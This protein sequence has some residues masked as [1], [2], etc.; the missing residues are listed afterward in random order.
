M[1]NELRELS[2]SLEKAGIKPPIFHYKFPLCPRKPAFMV[3]L[4]N[5]GNVAGVN[6]IPM[7]QV[8]QIRKWDGIG[9]LGTSFPAL[10]IP[11]LLMVKD[12]EHRKKLT[13][14]KKTANILPKEILK[15]AGGA[16]NLW[17]GR[18][19]GK[20]NKFDK[21]DTCLDKPVKDLLSK[22]TDTPSEFSAINELLLRAGKT[23]S[24]KLFSQLQDC[25]IKSIN[26]GDVKPIDALFYYGETKP[27]SQNDFQLIFE[28][29]DWKYFPANHQN[30]QHWMNSKLLSAE[31]G[32]A[33]VK[34]DAFGCNATGKDKKFPKVGF[35]NALGNVILRA[36]S[37]ENPSQFRYGMIN[38][39]SFPAGEEVRKEMTG[40]L[41][42][43]G[44]AENKGKTWCDLSR[45]LDRATLLFA[46]PSVIPPDL[47]DLASMMGD[48]QDA[49]SEIGKERFSTLAEKVTQALQGR[50]NATM[51]VDIRVFVL[52]KR[53][54]DARTKVIA[55][56]RYSDKH[57]IRSAR[58]W[59]EGSENI[60][61]ITIRSFGK[62]KGDKIVI[63]N[64]LIPFPV[65]T[66]WCLNTVWTRQ[67][68]HA[69]GAH[70]F[71]V[72]DSLCLLLGVGHELRHVAT[73]ALNV[74]LHNGLSLYLAL[75]QA[76]AQR[77]V[78][79]T[80]KKY[81]RQTLLLPSIL[82]LLLYKLGCKKGEIMKSP[83]FLVGRFMSIADQLHME[84]WKYFNQERP[85]SKP[86]RQLIGNSHMATALEQPAKAMAMLGQRLLLYQSWAQTVQE[87]ERVGLVKYFLD[88]FGKV[89]EQLNGA[90][91][92]AHCSDIDKAQMLLGYLARPESG[93]D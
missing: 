73:R 85:N 34:L 87:G 93:K 63:S 48:A 12:Q 3:Y 59:Q 54:G 56:S 88:Q 31:I 47:P 80:D 2:I 43:L 16:S 20:S 52:S 91:L 86:P 4:D 66:I 5:K 49:N 18:A 27:T 11:P 10:S 23:D 13:A 44:K 17:S 22:L 92:P 79:K 53:S 60:P 84:H 38:F 65:E 36:M 26:D 15:I 41:E 35:K 70:G 62:N 68:S 57:I 74:I 25:F 90:A 30:V 71:S 29:K 83:T 7:E 58:I 37:Q 33:E 24:K 6:S 21:V 76:N 64:P 28:I 45:R 1:L 55:N 67:G 32:K 69:E 61:E 39:E 78:H 14:M 77:L 19:G 50:V 82:G 75:G 42:W 89:S 72:N 8:Q 9:S 40:A 51:D 46:Y 81:V